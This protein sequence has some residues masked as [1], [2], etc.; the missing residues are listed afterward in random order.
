LTE[1]LPFYF[2]KPWFNFQRKGEYVPYHTHDGIYAYSLWLKIPKKCQF[3]FHYTNI[4]GNMQQ[5][6]IE[7]TKKDEGKIIFFPSTL[8]HVA[9]PFNGSQGIRISVSG[10][11]SL[12]SNG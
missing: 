1:N 10:N 7:L 3:E 8:P 9:Y 11:V 6:K 2:N 12:N 5:H 4:I